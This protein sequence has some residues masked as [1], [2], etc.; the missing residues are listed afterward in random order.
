[1]SS[2]HVKVLQVKRSVAIIVLTFQF[3]C[4]AA[5]LGGYAD[6]HSLQK[7]DRRRSYDVCI[8][9]NEQIDKVVARLTAPASV[10]SNASPQDVEAT[11]LRN[12]RSAASSKDIHDVL[13]ENREECKALLVQP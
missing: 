10:P 8:G 12:E 11:R 3:G 4:L 9:S 7:F 5:L 2:T 1:M 13:T 6:L